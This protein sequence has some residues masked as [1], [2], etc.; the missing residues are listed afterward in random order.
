[1]DE[2]FTKDLEFDLVEE[3]E[4]NKE[5]GIL[6]ELETGVQ[7]DDISY[8][9]QFIESHKPESNFKGDVLQHLSYVPML[10]RRVLSLLDSAV[11]NLPWVLLRLNELSSLLQ[12]EIRL[13]HNY[14]KDLY[15]EK[16]GELEALVP[17]PRQ[18]IQVIHVVENEGHNANSETLEREAGLSKE[19]IL[20]LK[21]SMKTS[22]KD[23]LPWPI[24]RREKLAE[25]RSNMLAIM[26]IESKVR[27]FVV[28][29]VSHVAPN[30]CA[31]IGPDVT[32]HLL[33]HAGG[34]LELSQIP[35]CNL[36]SI[37]KNKHLT[38]ELHTSLTGVR[39]EGYIYRSD[40]VQSQPY[41]YHKQVLRMACAK[42]ALAA[43]VDAGITPGSQADNSLG[44]KWKQEI[45]QKTLKQ[46]ESASISVVKPLPVPKEEAK[47]KR[48]GRKFRKYKQQF[49]LSHLR[50]L[51]NRMEFGKQE[52][53]TLDGFGE[54]IGLGMVNSSLQ[55]ATGVGSVTKTSVN[56]SAKL[57][58]AMKRRIEQANEQA[59]NTW[60]Q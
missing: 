50:Q 9:A 49:Q 2:D 51:Q 1:M 30:L 24:E 16:F 33:S 27:Q 35:S 7:D 23:N 55:Y 60:Q 32:S 58:K 29:K 3:E 44:F 54:E 56:N 38:H 10:E 22:Y 12:S 41:E 47:K 11:E 13:L 31:F 4:D 37:G 45:V 46:R 18:Y 21:M 17:N 26:E 5:Q 36:A 6:D 52:Q 15:Y 48:S 34:I 20:V 14:S 43:R 53:T 59:N 57:T 19:Q 40:L 28:E 42:V 8:L 25:A 39:Q